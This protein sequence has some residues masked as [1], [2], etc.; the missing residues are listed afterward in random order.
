MLNFLTL[1]SP[2]LPSQLSSGWDQ[3]LG[4]LVL[5]IKELLSQ[6]GMLL[7]QWQNLDGASPESQILLRAELKVK[8]IEICRTYTVLELSACLLMLQ[9]RFA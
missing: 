4:S 2:F 9:S 5:P 3:P 1:P 6:E 7:D 8:H